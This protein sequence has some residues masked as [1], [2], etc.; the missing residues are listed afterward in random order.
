M[1]VKTDVYNLILSWAASEMVKANEYF[2]N[3]DIGLYVNKTAQKFMKATNVSQKRKDAL[4]KAVIGINDKSKEVEKLSHEMMTY[5]AIDFLVN[6]EKDVSARVKYGH[7]ELSK[8]ISAME[9]KYKDELLD[10]YKFFSS[11]DD[12]IK[13]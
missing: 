7:I 11:I 8:I 6:V 13:G 1:L 12:N 10:H 4:L 3:K 9:A 2:V 5:L